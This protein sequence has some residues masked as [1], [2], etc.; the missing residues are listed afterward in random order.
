VFVKSVLFTVPFFFSIPSFR[1]P[2]GNALNY[3]EK[4]QPL[5]DKW[6]WH[7]VFALLVSKLEV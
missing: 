7:W 2:N 6:I 3:K 5:E 4:K 1:N